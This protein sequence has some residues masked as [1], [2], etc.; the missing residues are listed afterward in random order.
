MPYTENIFMKGFMA[1]LYLR[2]SC[3][4]CPTRCG[5][6]GSNITLGDFWGIDDVR[7]DLN[8]GQGISVVLV[9]DSKG[10]ALLEGVELYLWKVKYEDVLRNNVAL[11]VSAR[12]PANRKKFWDDN[13]KRLSKRIEKYTRFPLKLRI[14]YAT[15][16]FVSNMLGEKWKKSVSG[17]FKRW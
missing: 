8:D 5:R 17:L 4:V 13:G 6:S 10:K 12:E 14:K 15:I 2:P 1:N 7:P 3:Y 11:E 9:N 16:K